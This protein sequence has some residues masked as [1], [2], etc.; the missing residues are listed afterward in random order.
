MID[1][2]TFEFLA[3]LEQ[4]NNKAWFD[5]HRAEYKRLRREF[6]EFLA[7]IAQAVAFFDPAI[8]LH[9]D[10]PKLV[11]IFRI[12]RDIRFSK[13]KRPYKTNFA[14]TIGPRDGAGGAIYYVSIQPGES[15]AGGGIYMPPSPILQALREKVDQDYAE[16]AAIVGD[17]VFQA[18]FPAGLTR[19]DALKTAPRGYSVDHPGIEYLRL[20][21]FAAIRSFDDQEV[22][23][24]DFEDEVLKSF[25]A[26]SKLN[27]F[28]NQAIKAHQ[29]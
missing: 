17:P 26:L 15:A 16:L 13:D 4:N 9:L 5:E 18:A 28:L 21:S 7:D 23:S 2:A 12:N 1:P 8:Q 27:A 10:D 14:G 6:E 20:K 19:H 24:E 22:T 25:E 3:A 29:L 11:K